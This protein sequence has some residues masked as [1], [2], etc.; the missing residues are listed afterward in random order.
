MR[1]NPLETIGLEPNFVKTL[2]AEQLEKAIK[3][4]YNLQMTWWQPDRVYA[5]PTRFM[6]VR[7]AYEE[8]QNP[9]RMAE[10]AA[11]FVKKRTRKEIEEEMFQLSLQL[12]ERAKDFET[13]LTEFTFPTEN[14]IFSVKG[15]LGMSDTSRTLQQ[16]AEGDVQKR[17][18]RLFY[19]LYVEEQGI[20]KRY[21]SGEEMYDENKRL[22]GSITGQKVRD[23]LGGLQRLV[24]TVTDVP[25]LE[26]SGESGVARAVMNIDGN[27]FRNTIL[28]IIGTD[29]EEGAYIFAIQ[30]LDD[31]HVYSLEGRVAKSA[32]M[33]EGEL[34]YATPEVPELMGRR[35]VRFILGL[36]RQ[37]Q[38]LNEG[39]VQ[40]LTKMY[41]NGEINFDKVRTDIVG[42]GIGQGKKGA[43]IQAVDRMEEFLKQTEGY[44]IDGRLHAKQ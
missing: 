18:D 32:T 31:R 36:G 21:Q 2:N 37:A 10:C 39:D 19:T 13:Y 20:R 9:M 30:R 6:R 29:V 11:D 22:I 41:G 23:E 8:L 44:K 1:Q 28:P 26:G 17:I 33:E 15:P 14:S 25:R 38:R 24:R 5:N 7:E 16:G 35:V 4:M 43:Y 27:T 3:H 40:R 34:M 12:S 42:Q